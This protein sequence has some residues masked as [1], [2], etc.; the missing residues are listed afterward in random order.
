MLLNVKL[1]FNFFFF[2]HRKLTLEAQ[3]KLHMFLENTKEIKSWVD[4]LALKLDHL[5]KEEEKFDLD[6]RLR[7]LSDYRLELKTK[8]EV[9]ASLTEKGQHLVQDGQLSSMEVESKLNE[10]NNGFHLVAQTLSNI[11]EYSL[12]NVSFKV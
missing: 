6:T 7:V 1:F 2:F 3:R 10:I 12:Q 5:S 9:V 8:I 11:E 4:S